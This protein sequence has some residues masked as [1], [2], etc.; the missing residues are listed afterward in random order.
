MFSLM[1][2]CKESSFG[3]CLLHESGEYEGKF[4]FPF[5]SM[6]VLSNI[7]QDDL[8]NSPIGNLSRF[9]ENT[10][11][12]DELIELHEKN[13]DESQWIK[14]FKK[15]FLMTWDY[16][17]TMEQIN[18][19]RAIVHP[20][21]AIVAPNY[22]PIENESPLLETQGALSTLKILDLVQ[23]REA[24]GI[25]NGHR[26]LWG[27]AGSGKTI[28]LISRAKI[29]AEE[30]PS[31]RILV[32]CF[33]I[34]LAVYLRETLKN[35]PAVTVA[36]FHE[37]ARNHW[38][39]STKKDESPGDFGERILKKIAKPS[40]LGE[41][42]YD[43]IL[44]DEAQDFDPSWF[45][46]ILELLADRYDG[47][48]IIVGDGKQSLYAT[49]K[50]SWKSIGIQAQGR[51]TYF[52][53]NYRN[54]TEIIQVASKFYSSVLLSDKEK[55][56]I[57][58]EEM[59]LDV[60]KSLRQTGIKPVLLARKDN[61]EMIEEF[62][63]IVQGL[64][65]GEFYGKPLPEPLHPSEIAIL[66]PAR[67]KSIYIAIPQLIAELE[68]ITKVHWL[69]APKGI[70]K[71]MTCSPNLKV[72]TIHSAKGLQYKAVL[73]LGTEVLPIN[74][75]NTSA[76]D[77]KNA[78]IEGEKLIYVAITRAE[79]ILVIA[80]TSPSVFTKRFEEIAANGFLDTD[81]KQ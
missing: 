6:V 49:R 80:Y 36:H 76:L 65:N 58:V 45:K 41:I 26:L 70:Y 28:M 5:G 78:I 71:Q 19:L 81:L 63:K 61:K 47:D 72:S 68:T 14:V 24:R 75:K 7:K 62:V 30:N 48:L 4:L 64:L 77:S 17:M 51:T 11:N 21:I 29:L 59:A 74:A 8:E 33:N 1:T 55:E 20:E 57:G 3:A 40:E 13:Y 9:F 44:V 42:K 56:D 23:E 16:H 46:C 27:V 34:T 66:Y 43:M 79:N 53:I 60:S 10:I 35:Y 50:I 73:L 22:V 15:Y 67:T 32:T 12:H 38:H 37:I 54:S 18:T 2:A 39:I 25:G 69:N 31:A 52:K